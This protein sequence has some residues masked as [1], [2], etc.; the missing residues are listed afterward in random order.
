MSI[1]FGVLLT[2]L[3]GWAYAT[4]DPDKQSVTALIPAIP[5]VVLIACGALALNEK[6]IKHAMHAA[7]LFGVLGF[8]GGAANIVRA[9]VAGKE[10]SDR[11]VL[12]SIGMTVLCGAFTALCV[13]SF[14]DVRRAKARAAQ[15]A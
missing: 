12:V 2:A 1:V 5:G 11:P 13:K 8:L 15:A 10:L 7:A 6:W 4:A 9:L 14:I 3:G